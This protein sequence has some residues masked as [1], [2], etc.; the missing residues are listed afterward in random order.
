LIIR[1]KYVS[2]FL[3]SIG[4]A[5]KY[6]RARGNL[7]PTLPLNGPGCITNVL[8]NALKKL[9]QCVNALKTLTLRQL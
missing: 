2:N 3:Y 7:P 1:E 8:I 9:T 6:R 5:P 4:W